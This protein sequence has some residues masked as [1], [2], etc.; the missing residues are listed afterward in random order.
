MDKIKNILVTGGSGKIGR[1]L[2]PRLLHEGYRLRVLEFET[3][4]LPYPVENVELAR[5]ELG[6]PGLALE[7][8]KD[9]D[10][11]IH[12]AN[13]KENKERFMKANIQGTFDLL[14]AVYTSGKQVRQFIQAGSDARAGIYYNPRPYTM[15]ENF[16]HRAYPG[17][18]PFSK[19]LE[20]TMCEQYRCQYGLPVTVLR[21]SWVHDEDDIL[22]HGTLRKPDFGIPVWKE[23]AE[24]QEQK[25]FF[26]QDL[27]AAACMVHPDGTPCIR[28]IVALEDCIT[29]IFC[30]LGNPAAAGHA[31]TVAAP[32]A[33]SYKVLAEYISQK[34]DIPVLNFTNPIYHD[35]QHDLSKSRSILGFNPSYDIIRM[36]DKAL[37]FRAAGHT[38]S[39]CKYPG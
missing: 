31:F 21:F 17:Y 7:L 39:S 14:D 5:G 25:Y 35:F 37:E 36:V 38:R 33:F 34:L 9:M 23:L 24:T 27:D 26:E 29:S 18:Y 16:P 8:I 28:H 15:D 3:D 2:I 4:E 30:A 22:A 6:T 32:S 12:L 20:E 10:C 1:H 19:V 13:T 11:V